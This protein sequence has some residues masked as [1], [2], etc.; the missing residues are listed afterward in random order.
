MNNIYTALQSTN[1]KFSVFILYPKR[2]LRQLL[3]NG[4]LNLEMRYSIL[5]RFTERRSTLSGLH[6]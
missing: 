1:L 3:A 6:D 4:T 2:G 5:D